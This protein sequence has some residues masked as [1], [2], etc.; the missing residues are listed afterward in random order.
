MAEIAIPL[1]ALGSMYIV[2]KQK[3]KKIKSDIEGSYAEGYT[4]MTK[5]KNQLPGI[6][7]PNPPINFPLT[8]PVKTSNNTSAYMN[9]NQ[10]T[11]KFF[12][13]ANYSQQE[14]RNNG[15]YGVGG[16]TQTAYSMT[17]KPIDKDQFK[18]NNMMPFFGGKIRGATADTNITES[19]LDNMQGQGSQ[20]FAKKERRRAKEE[21]SPRLRVRDKTK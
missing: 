2:S 1:I 3:D 10:T 21:M 14:T 12:N 15:N 20:F 16:G 6:N 7:P 11:D 5:I 4:N 8:E 17:G 19:V 18:H 9:P 13:P